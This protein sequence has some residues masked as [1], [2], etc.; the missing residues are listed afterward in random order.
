MTTK[1]TIVNAKA[2][3]LLTTT[4]TQLIFVMGESMVK[5]IRPWLPLVNNKGL[6]C[7]DLHLFKMMSTYMI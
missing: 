1:L 4:H 6:I 5:I 3:K 7:W 2:I